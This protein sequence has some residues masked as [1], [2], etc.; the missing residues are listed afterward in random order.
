LRRPF[1][2]LIEEK[3]PQATIGFI[4]RAGI[5][6]QHGSSQLFLPMIVGADTAKRTSLGLS[7]S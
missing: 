2:A 5:P 7:I 6:A 1:K 4:A 3:R